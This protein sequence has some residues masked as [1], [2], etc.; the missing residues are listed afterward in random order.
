MV[1][2]P[3]PVGPKA[4]PMSKKKTRRSDDNLTA[5][6]AGADSSGGFSLTVSEEDV[7]RAAEEVLGYINF[8]SGPADPRVFAN[9]NRLYTALESTAETSPE[10]AWRRLYHQLHVRL[11]QLQA[12]SPA[13]HR[14]EQA[15][16]LLPMVFE[17]LLPAFLDWH[18]DLLAHQS[19][20]ALYRPYF[21]GRAIEAV[22]AQGGPWNDTSR[23]V[24][25]AIRQ[26]NDYVGYRPVA[27]LETEQKI[28][29]YE[30]E[31]V[32]LI[33]LYLRGAGPAVGR[34]RELIDG[35]LGILENTSSAILFQAYCERERLEELSMDPRAYDFDHPVNKRPNYLYGQWDLGKLDTAGYAR[36]FVV[37][38][39]S[40]EAIL[41]RVENEHELPR[42][43]VL[44]EAAAVLAC[45][46]LMGSGISANRPGAHDSNA[47]LAS[48][49]QPIAAYRDEFY[50]QLLR[51][52]PG[53][54]G[55]RLKREAKQLHQP[56]GGARQHFNRYMTLRRA[57]QLQ[58]IHLALLHARIGA[59]DAA[60]RQVRAVPVAAARMSCD[61]EC[62][63]VAADQHLT[64]GRLE[65]AL[66]STGEAE[67]LLHRA[68]RCGAMVDPWNILGFGG[69]FSLF[70]AIE[71]SVHDFR[72]D[73]LMET[74]GGLFDLLVQVRKD[75][76]ATGNEAVQ[77]KA[78][79]RLDV[80]ARWWDK[81]ATVEV[82]G[83]D[84]V[85]GHETCESAEHVAEALRAWHAAGTAAGDLGFWRERVE[86]FQ[87]PKAYALVVD[88]LLER[89]DPVAAMALLVQW[90]SRVDTIPLSEE[91]Y[92]FYDLV[93]R[94]MDQLWRP[95]TDRR[96]ALPLPAEQ[97]WAMARKFLD[98][99]EANAEQ[100]WNCP[101]FQLAE[102]SAA[103]PNGEPAGDDLLAEEE[104]ED[105]EDDFS[106]LYGAA[107]ENVTFRDSADDGID[108]S[109]FDTGQGGSD[110]ELV[111]EAER[112]VRRLSFL[113]MLAQLW[114]QAALGALE[115]D[116]PDRDEEL[117]R[118]LRR[119]EANR[120]A[121]LGLLR[122][123]H[124][125]HLP[126]PRSTPDSLAEFDRR[127]ALKE[128]LLDQ[129]STT[130]LE[131]ADA[132]R[133]IRVAMQTPSEAESG[134]DWEPPM[135]RVLRAV[136][137]DD[138][139]G[140]RS[141]WRSLL[142]S[143]RKHPLLFVAVAR[144]GD[145]ANIIASRGIQ[146]MLLRLLAYLPRMGMLSE[147]A[148]L[149]Q[150]AQ[151]MELE[152][153]VGPGAITEFDHLFQAGLR[154]IIRSL[155]NSAED[156][157]PQLPEASDAPLV[158]LLER[159]VEALMRLWFTHSRGLRLSPV[160]ML[161][162]EKRWR[163][164]KQFIVSYGDELFTQ[165]FLMNVGNLR[166]ILHEGVQAYLDA[167]ADEG[168]NEN[169]LRLIRDMDRRIGRKA[170]SRS[171]ELILE[172][173]LEYYPEYVDY[174]NTTT[175]SDRGELLY[176]LLDQLRVLG[177][178]Q[179]VAMNLHPVVIVHDELVR[180]GRVSA[181]EAWQQAVAQQSA[182]LADEHVRRFEELS[183]TYGMYLRSIADRLSERFIQPLAVDRLRALVRPALREQRKGKGSD[184]FEQLR[185]HIA[186]F[187]ENLSGAGFEVPGWLEALEDEV[188]NIREGAGSDADLPDPM[189]TI[190]THRLSWETAVRQVDRIGRE[191]T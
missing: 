115:E 177:S 6:T 176:T 49:I 89:G 106:G 95:D 145:P 182:E 53:K 36:R 142:R 126:G 84:G 100:Y 174:N 78:A 45:I 32:A 170:A 81:F 66:Q 80:L 82:V 175:Q 132:A 101:D 149:L 152:H 159:L 164:I 102:E 71:N 92:A 169:D 48:L 171:L 2:I 158:A 98:Y 135:Q 178:Y 10:P 61:I 150:M 70:P 43:E 24:Q 121:L 68:I 189:L 114:K 144:G 28:Q 16:V 63:M 148:Q 139:R 186:P 42:E 87:S 156:W 35:A 14:S 137:R 167:L 57:E 134:A 47:T 21:L 117:A 128:M 163:E 12:D 103:G 162:D 129:I 165:R 154:G 113:S 180:G 34:Y 168:G 96:K 140:V 17:H 183:R 62:R 166:A 105:E 184:A 64:D 97:R 50:E 160:E 116:T 104:E 173:I 138:R 18:A 90:L 187:A 65:D 5:Q 190:R 119:A 99:I 110:E 131:T 73:E 55:R 51:Q 22:L 143:L 125:H 77:R 112:L 147:T 153:P 46:M 146:W 161:Q 86:Q 79:E 181:A 107:Y 8:A 179:R 52:I 59:L 141:A 3:R 29:P 123:V 40:L 157:A 109:L 9:L 13:F 25:G 67:D 30:H 37:H 60:S 11:A 15:A 39:I 56:L 38:E 4:M 85:S 44:Y 41:D 191:M 127:L 1:V 83:D 54:H 74:V 26:M 88:A 31:W 124:R 76:A 133:V 120:E 72:V 172:I 7:A 155:V 75:A 69:Q 91:G 188:D 151:K 93:L 108:S 27:V 58:N 136:V 185:E 33:P 130:C 19:D 23:I 118:W 20:A 94:W 122:T 111:H